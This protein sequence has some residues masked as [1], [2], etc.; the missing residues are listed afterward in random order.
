M[1]LDRWHGACVCPCHTGHGAGHAPGGTHQ[2]KARFSKARLACAAL[3]MG[4]L[5]FAAG[6]AQAPQAPP[7]RP[8]DIPVFPPPPEVARIV[9]ERALHSSADVVADDKDGSLRRMVTGEVRTGEGLDKPYGVA[10]RGGRVYVGDTVA[11]NVVVF[12][13]NAGSF[14][15]IG[16]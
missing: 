2:M 3:G 11:R 12:D 8:A 13:L 6:C 14:N 5:L 10:V 1:P 7:A 16:V 4:V 9:W 15:R